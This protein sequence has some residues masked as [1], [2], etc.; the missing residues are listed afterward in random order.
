MLES[1]QKFVC[2]FFPTR[3]LREVAKSL[4]KNMARVVFI[5]E[6]EE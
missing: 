1:D 4:K 5:A 6:W 3:L 2:F